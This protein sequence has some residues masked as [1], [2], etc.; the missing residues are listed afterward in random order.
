MKWSKDLKRQVIFEGILYLIQGFMLVLFLFNMT[1]KFLAVVL[2]VEFFMSII[3]TVGW[4]IWVNKADN[5]KVD[6]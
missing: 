4:F 2:L 3:A 6:P 5:K 1:I